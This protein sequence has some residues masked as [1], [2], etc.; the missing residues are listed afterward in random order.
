MVDVIRRVAV[1][2]KRSIN[3]KRIILYRTPECHSNAALY[4]AKLTKMILE[5]K[6]GNLLK[7]GVGWNYVI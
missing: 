2:I 3:G 4:G 5:W 6:W 7:K 1:K